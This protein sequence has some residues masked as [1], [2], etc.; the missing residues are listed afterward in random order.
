M[1]ISDILSSVQL[2]SLR[3][4]TGGP[5]AEIYAPQI[6]DHISERLY[7]LAADA[8][9]ALN[10]QIWRKIGEKGCG[11]LEFVGKSAKFIEVR[12]DRI[13]GTHLCGLLKKGRNLVW[14]DADSCYIIGWDTWNETWDKIVVSEMYDETLP[15]PMT[16]REIRQIRADM[17]HRRKFDEMAEVTRYKKLN[18]RG[19]NMSFTE[20]Q[21]RRRCEE[22]ERAIRTVVTESRRIMEAL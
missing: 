2:Q 7:A 6:P 8:K 1:R 5:D 21:A 9:C 14:V 3:T 13:F 11:V 16:R 10:A 20:Q 4:F 18:K 19:F 12:F 15:D 22:Y 17:E